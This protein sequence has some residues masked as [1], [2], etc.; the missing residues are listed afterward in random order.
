MFLDPR[1]QAQH[2]FLRDF[3]AF[4]FSDQSA[5]RMISTR[6]DRFKSSGNSE[7]ISIMPMPCP[8]SSSIRR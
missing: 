2:A 1:H 8:A 4:Q 3:I 6:D 5:L 7:E